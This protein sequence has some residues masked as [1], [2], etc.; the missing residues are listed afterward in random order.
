MN[1]QPH[2]SQP[3]DIYLWGG[4]AETLRAA[5]NLL[6]D[7]GYTPHLIARPD[8]GIGDTASSSVPTDSSPAAI[9]LQAEL[10]PT[11]AYYRTR[12]QQSTQAFD[13]LA[14]AIS[15]DLQAPVRHLQGFASALEQQL[16]ASPQP[17]DPKALHYLDIIQ[18]SSQKLATLIA[19]LLTLSRVGT[20][21]LRLTSVALPQLVQ[22][23][24]AEVQ[25]SRAAPNVAITVGDLPTVTGDRRLLH[26]ALVHLIDNAVKFTAIHC[27]PTPSTADQRATNAS[28]SSAQIAIGTRPDGTIF[29]RDNGLGFGMDQAEQLFVPLQR[30][31]SRQDIPGLGLGLAIVHRIIL[32][33]SGTIWATSQPGQGATF[34][35]KLSENP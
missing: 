33:H 25:A 24:I 8:A 1:S 15:H 3:N 19:G 16:A 14:Y 28:E 26:Q 12:L 4:D 29:I 10:A 6:V 31:H 35:L 21:E 2:S 32:R 5:M 18:S 13:G 30:L 9:P 23:A 11:L 22:A 7:H 34:Y 20:Q 27:I 17:I